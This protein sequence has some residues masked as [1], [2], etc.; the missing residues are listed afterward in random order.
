VSEPLSVGAVVA[1]AKDLGILETVKNKLFN[2]PGAAADKLAAVLA[3]L[4]KIYKLL[5]L[6]L[7]KFSSLYFAAEMP[8]EDRLEAINELNRLKGNRMGAQTENARAHC[9]KIAN[10]YKTHLTGV[11]DRILNSDEQKQI[12]LLFSFLSEMDGEMVLAMDKVLYWLGQQ[13][14]EVLSLIEAQDLVG[15][16]RLVAK[17]RP[18][19]ND[20]QDALAGVQNRLA[21]LNAEFIKLSGAS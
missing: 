6:E 10:I 17:A 4:S 15:A 21:K 13:A 3:E 9:H 20:A 14:T 11:F 12:T 5:D 8:E 7:T 1:I 19:I 16:N 2:H 18:A